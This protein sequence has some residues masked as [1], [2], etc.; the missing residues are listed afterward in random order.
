MKN[1]NK[2]ES[3][4]FTGD[5]NNSDNVNPG[6]FA[7]AAKNNVNLRIE[8]ETPINEY[9]YKVAGRYRLAMIFFG[10]LIIAYVVVIV[11][12]FKSE[13]TYDNL[14]YAVRD[15]NTDVSTP[16]MG[17]NN[18]KLEEE[19]EM[20]F[21]IYRERLAVASNS[22]FVL[23]NTAGSKEIHF[24]YYMENPKV[25]TSDK[26]TF[27]YDVGKTDY[28]IYNTLTK[29]YDRKHDYEIQGA[30]VSKSGSYA[31]ISKC[32]ENKFVVHFYDDN[33]INVYNSYK[34]NYVMDV[35]LDPTGKKYVIAAV[36]V[37]ETDFVME[38]QTG[39]VESEDAKKVTV[40]G[41]MPL[42]A[43]FLDNGSVC[44]VCDRGIVFCDS[45][46]EIL[47]KNTFTDLSLLHSYACGNRVMIAGSTDTVGNCNK[48]IVYNSDG[49]EYTN[50]SV[51]GKMTSAAM[52]EDYIFYSTAEEIGR[53]SF[54]G[55]KESEKTDITAKQLIPDGECVIVCS[56]SKVFTAF[57][58]TVNEA[59]KSENTD[60][61]T[62]DTAAV[63]S[64]SPAEESR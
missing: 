41:Y 10:L 24:S 19:S 51:T 26:Y 2:N 3:R 6:E 63:Q 28:Q 4:S 57:D 37:A 9:Y 21:G 56:T 60:D 13:I 61:V 50:A 1:R 52:G 32:E 53:I 44:V 27:V 31:I 38:I 64:D 18:M 54:D 43:Y 40:A 59:E 62:S 48:I 15:I 22:G 5:N 34:D 42:R 58:S 47:T 55:S 14:M 36:D 16:S 20:S 33:F 45:N 7:P 39:T 25:L 12:M 17:F 30:A 11:V 23:Y 29:V 49:T 35:A 8:R 46:G